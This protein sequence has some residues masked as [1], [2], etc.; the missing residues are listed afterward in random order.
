MKIAFY[1]LGIVF[2]V[3]II[4]LGAR[5]S[6]EKSAKDELSEIANT[7]KLEFKVG[8][9]DQLALGIQMSKSPLIVSYMENP[10]NEDL[11]EKAYAEVKSYQGSFL[12]N[13]TFMINDQDLIYHINCVPQYVLDKNDPGSA[14]YGFTSQMTKDYDLF[15]DYEKA[16]DATFCW[17]NAI[18]RDSNRKFLGII[19]TGIPISDFVDTMYKDLESNISM[20]LYDSSLEVSGSTDK[21]LMESKA[22]IRSVISDMNSKSDE[23]IT[24]KNT[25]FFGNF[26]TI[27]SITPLEEVG[28]YILLYKK[29]NFVNFLSCMTIPLVLVLLIL[30]IQILIVIFMKIFKPL[31]E[32][33]RATNHLSS[34]EADLSRRINIDSN[35]S[36]GSLKKLSSGFNG[37]IQKVQEIITSVKN[38]KD[39]LVETGANLRT[40]TDNT[41]ESISQILQSID[42]FD[43]T[44][45]N[46]AESVQQTVESVNKISN[47]IQTLDNL[48]ETQ[49]SSVNQA[50]TSI[51]KMISAI[52]V[53]NGSVLNLE[54]SFDSL[55]KNARAGIEKQNAVNNKIEEIQNQ[56][57]ML[58]EA[59]TTISAIAEQTNLLA[60]NAA[61]EAAH[62]GEAGKGFSVVADEIRSLAETS[63]E[64]SR[65]IGNQLIAIQESISQIVQASSETK[66][67]F[68]TF[69]TEIKTTNAIISGITD[70]MK[71]QE[72]DTANINSVL[73]VLN[74]S[75][76]EVKAASSEMTESS[77][78]ILSE[79]QSLE[80][81]TNNMKTSMNSMNHGATQIGQTGQELNTLSS[82]MENTISELDL[83]MNKFKV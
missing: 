83:Q 45:S 17:V 55:E 66:A 14:W 50:E 24:P 61:I 41:S 27:Y 2:S 8:F 70:S 33:T 56:S 20:Y 53:V 43:V 67:A 19:G 47:N 52:D 6:F 64:Q 12:S 62:A 54:Q 40:C 29:F 25:Y 74:T 35:S 37:F 30:I 32:L 51:Q 78:L 42:A 58:Q 59:N 69:A 18:V 81:S 36:L 3:I 77:G 75:T 13:Q 10:F 34:G 48:I 76:N 71:T 16:L 9:K 57:A 21:S 46:Q 5:Y 28:W 31:S 39:N 23:E 26:G 65:T 38:S 15:V 72:E 60:M 7:K 49:V 11:K 68:D 79:V 82:E 80:I 1:G 22:K 73:R 44:I 4:I 63:S